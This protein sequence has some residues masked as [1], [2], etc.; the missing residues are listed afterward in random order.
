MN[1]YIN[2]RYAV[3]MKVR[4]KSKRIRQ[5]IYEVPAK[6]DADAYDCARRKANRAG[7]FP[8]DCDTVHHKRHRLRF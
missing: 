3:L 5:N 8:M 6:D 7:H 1:L 2:Y 4:M